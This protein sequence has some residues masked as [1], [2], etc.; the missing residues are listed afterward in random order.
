[1]GRGWCGGAEGRRVNGVK[2]V[3]RCVSAD[4]GDIDHPIAELNEGT[5]IDTHP[6][7]EY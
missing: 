1:M 7:L 6:E 4:W 3:V 2:G 5:P